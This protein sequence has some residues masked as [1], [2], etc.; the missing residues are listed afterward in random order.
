MPESYS[1]QGTGM[2]VSS[3]KK[4]V[5]QL[6]YTTS[7]SLGYHCSYRDPVTGSPRKKKFGMIPRAEAEVAY[8]LWL[9]E[10]LGGVMSASLVAD[11]PIVTP[12]L[13]TTR[14]KATARR[15][16][17]PPTAAEVS[18]SSEDANH[19]SSSGVGG[20]AGGGEECVAGCL[21]LV[22]ESLLAYE[23]SR[24]REPAAGRTHGTVSAQHGQAFEKHVKDFLRHLNT[25]YGQG[26]LKRMQLADLL[27]SDVESY[28]RAVADQG[29]SASVVRKRMQAVKRLIDRAGRPELG[30]QV[31][32]W[33]WQS[34]DVFHGKAGQPRT[35]PTLCQLQKLLD[36][37]DL[38]GRTLIWLGIG[39]GFGQGDLAVIRACHID[40]QGYDLR[41]GKTGIDRYGDTPP[42][43]WAL[44]SAY[45]QSSGHQ[46]HPDGLLFTTRQGQPLVHGKTDT[47]KQW[48]NKLRPRV[49]ESSETLG[50]FYTLRHLGATE[51]GSR[52][53]TS[54]GDMKRWLGHSASS[55]MADVYMRP[56]SPE[57][58]DV[59]QFVRRSLATPVKLSAA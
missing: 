42:G 58:R 46:P 48:W 40:A 36:A 27:M 29:H 4:R 57:H 51:F 14:R 25:R 28:N 12:A 33:N 47:V 23:R 49:G 37:A 11:D 34:R 26:C 30:Q 8:H 2:S 6:K 55:K 35:L 22:A 53:G 21:L 10:H 19:R 41:R 1:F 18:S 15:V 44:V 43:V 13:A 52:P 39:L 3:R 7:R 24:V 38:R 59:V 20:G 5:P 32:S 45:L 17:P 56:V 31:L 9:A 50:G 16:S 54:I